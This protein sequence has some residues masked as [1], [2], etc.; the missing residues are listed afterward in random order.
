MREESVLVKLFSGTASDTEKTTSTYQQNRLLLE[1][2][3]DI[4][5]LLS[6]ISENTVKKTKSDANV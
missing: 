5:S 6:K 2:L 4:R 1:V 3:L